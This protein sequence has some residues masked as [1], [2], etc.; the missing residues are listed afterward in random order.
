M[1]AQRFEWRIP[2]RSA[3]LLAAALA[4]APAAL[5]HR[6]W[7]LPS[8][9]VLS[10]AEAWVTVD[11]AVSNTLFVFEHRPLRLEGLAVSGPGGRQAPPQ[12][13][14][15]GHF[16]SSFDLHLEAPGTYRISLANASVMASWKENGEWKRWRGPAAEMAAHV[17][18][19]AAELQVSRNAMRVETYVT[20]G[21]PTRD[22]LA[23]AG[24]GLEI[25][26]ET[27]PNDLVAGEE[28][29][30]VILLDG[31]PAAGVELTVAQGHGRHAQQPAEQKLASDAQ[32]R[33]RVV[34]PTPGFYWLQAAAGGG[35]GRAG[36]RASCALTVEVLPQ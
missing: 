20:L 34:F 18:Q 17:P 6:V 22:V 33:V 14:H 16:R 31:K 5:A 29:V 9:T 32:G 25:L 35:P 26:P 30:F 24:A 21:K 1:K 15:T 28:A 2:G 36:S 23:P 10:G 27:H 11:A 8:T 4:F 13:V 3:A 19:Q 7:L 12:N